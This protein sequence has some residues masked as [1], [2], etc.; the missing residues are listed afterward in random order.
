MMIKVFPHGKGNGIGP[1][2]YLVRQDYHGRKESPP[3]VLRGDPDMTRALIDSIDRE[4]KFTAG[5]CSWGPEDAITPEKE[6]EVMDSFEA[7]AFAGMQP[8]QYSILWVRHS[9]A[10]HHELHFVIPRMELSTGKA[11]NALGKRFRPAPRSGK[12]PVWMDAPRRS[13]AGAV[14]RPVESRPP[15][16]EADPLGEESNPEREGKSAGTYQ[17]IPQGEDRNRRRPRPRRCIGRAPGGGA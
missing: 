17:R 12:H 14:L 16:G 13:G 10:G 1:T 9:H 5:V 11:F 6:Q 2:R 8:D 3:V 7:V 4:W 15:R